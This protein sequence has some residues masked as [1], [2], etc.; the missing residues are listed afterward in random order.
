MTPDLNSREPSK[1]AGPRRRQTI[2]RRLKR[3]RKTVRRLGRAWTAMPP[4]VRTLAILIVTAVV[5]AV[6]NLV[7]QVI[8][9]PT[10]V[11]FPADTALNKAPRD[12][13]RQY[14][15]LFRRYSTA[16][17]TPEL[18]AALAQVEGA[19]NPLARTYWRW[20]LTWHPFAIYRPASSAVGMYQMTD[21]AFADARDFC[22]REHRVVRE[23]CGFN[24]LYNRVLPSDA[25]QL[26]AVYLERHVEAVLA[27]FPGERPSAQQRQDLATLIHLC[28]AGPAEAFARYRF[29]LP[30]GERCGDHDAA[31]YLA[32]V[33]A[34]K[35]VFR[36]LAAGR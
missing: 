7:Y 13:W 35:G 33:N 9:K 32:K 2:R 18:L 23:G 21:P 36:R 20:S 8:R 25:I 29:R 28:G 12:T 17:I 27:R 4:A 26:T 24:D 5:L 16:I 3:W 10:E 34:M 15:R 11:F 31:T 14:G 22:I 1:R 30:A 19:G 6:S